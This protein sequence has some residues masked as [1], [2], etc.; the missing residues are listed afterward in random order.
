MAADWIRAEVFFAS[1]YSYRIPNTSPS[2]A[3][4][5][6]VPSP[7]AVRLALVDAAIQRN[8]S[9]TEG[10]EIFDVVRAAPLRLVPPERVC[11][12]RAFTKRLKPLQPKTREARER[13]QE[14]RLVESTGIREYCHPSGPLEIYIE[15]EREAERIA[16]LFGLLRRLGTTDS[17]A[18]CR[19]EIGPEPP[20]ELTCHLTASL[21]VE[22]DNFARRMAVTLLEF[23]DNVTFDDVN[24]YVQARRGFKY[25]QQLW[26]LPLV[27][28]QR[29][30][31]WILYE[32]EPFVLSGREA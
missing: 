26:S 11:V 31:N 9:V 25:E 22:R 6:P 29:G 4:A 5:S 27:P 20:E 18:H 13:G 1:M 17:L 12:V 3:P 15:A 8:G 7:S 16:Q 19:A 14:K 21:A 24:P 28:R 23:P 30:E 10:R 2:F 32:R